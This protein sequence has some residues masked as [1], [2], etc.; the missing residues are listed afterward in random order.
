MPLSLPLINTSNSAS[1][2]NSSILSTPSSPVNNNNNISALKAKYTGYTTWLKRSSRQNC[3]PLLTEELLKR[4]LCQMGINHKQANQLVSKCKWY[5][6]QFQHDLEQQ[7]PVDEHDHSDR[8]SSPF[9]HNR[10]PID[11]Q[12]SSLSTHKGKTIFPKQRF[13]FE[14]DNDVFR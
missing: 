7:Q 13:H 9:R 3:E 1:T 10:S 2:C 14:S 4:S 12:S 6:Y 5:V 8:S 11:D